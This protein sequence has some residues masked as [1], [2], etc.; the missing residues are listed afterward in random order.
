ML[1]GHRFCLIKD[2]LGIESNGNNNR[3][4]V[5]V[6]PGETINVLS[7]PRPDD[8]RM[9]DVQWGDK[10]LV[11]FFEDIQTRSEEVKGKPA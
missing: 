10:T 4:A 7:G 6:P 1:T 5:V 8:K 9:V 11:M 3:V 2:I